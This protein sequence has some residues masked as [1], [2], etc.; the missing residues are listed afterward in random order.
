MVLA[1]IR[2]RRW[3][4]R[5]WSRGAVEPSSPA[6]GHPPLSPASR[7]RRAG[8]D[9]PRRSASLLPLLD[10]SCK[11]AGP[12]PRRRGPGLPGSRGAGRGGVAVGHREGSATTIALPQSAAPITRLHYI[13]CTAILG[14]SW[15]LLSIV[16][17]Y[18]SYIILKNSLR[19]CIPGTENF[20]LVDQSCARPA[21]GGG[22]SRPSRASGVGVG[23][24]AL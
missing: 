11:N 12:E 18:P 13:L 4:L 17:I 14:K 19:E 9:V 8:G 23:A 6:P 21:Q 24:G 3:A 15:T 20:G 2:R 7:G 16:V 10:R 5:P 22:T 1:T